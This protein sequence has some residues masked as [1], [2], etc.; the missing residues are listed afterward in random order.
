MKKKLACVRDGFFHTFSSFLL[1]FQKLFS[2]F[3][4]TTTL[5]A[6]EY[7]DDDTQDC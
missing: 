5:L 2:T 7:G 3:A 1:L 4:K 6:H